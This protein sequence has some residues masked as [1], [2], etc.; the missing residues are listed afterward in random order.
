MSDTISHSGVV[1]SIS[2]NS[3]RVRILQASACAACKVASHCNASE[4]K[5]KTVNVDCSDAH[6]YK[7]GQA[8]VVTASKAVANKALLIGFGLPLVVLVCTLVSLLALGYDE[9]TAALTALAMLAPYYGVV[10]LLR[11]RIGRNVA[12]AIEPVAAQ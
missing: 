10:W 9:G 8:V 6:R 3:V 7:L 1:E 4:A 5:V 2:G 12:F 11:R